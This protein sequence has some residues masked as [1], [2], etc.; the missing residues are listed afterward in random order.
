M[1]LAGGAA[2]FFDGGADFAAGLAFAGFGARDALV[3]FACLPFATTAFF[4]GF[5]AARTA[6]FF[7][8]FFATGRAAFF[9]TGLAA[10]LAGDFF[11]AAIVVYLVLMMGTVSARDTLPDP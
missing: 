4:G 5:G 6:D 10:F 11:A 9:A 2:T 1:P 8:T 3:D 7:V